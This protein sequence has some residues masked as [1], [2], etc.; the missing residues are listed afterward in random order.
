MN[1]YG[2][3][4]QCI[5]NGD[6]GWLSDAKFMLNILSTT[7]IYLQLWCNGQP[8]R[9]SKDLHWKHIYI[10]ILRIH[11]RLHSPLA[12]MWLLTALEL[13]ISLCNNQSSRCTCPLYFE[14]ILRPSAGKNK[15]II[16]R[17]LCMS[18]PVCSVGLRQSVNLQERLC[19][20]HS[21][22]QLKLNMH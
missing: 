11:D 17:L 2:A 22:L 1:V 5:W 21:G 9:I 15:N 20:V 13:F 19:M 10:L 12:T 4:Y 3:V 8:A 6:V 16:M 7:C 14:Q 18:H